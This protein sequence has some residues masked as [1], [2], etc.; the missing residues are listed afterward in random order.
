MP[1]NLTGASPFRLSPVDKDEDA[2]HLP[3][4]RYGG[5]RSAWVTPNVKDST[6][7][8]GGDVQAPSR[9]RPSLWV[10]ASRREL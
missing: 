7:S 6:A 4:P 2:P 5:S 3:P 10:A 9:S 8:F 1:A